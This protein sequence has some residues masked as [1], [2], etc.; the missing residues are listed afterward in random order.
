VLLHQG[1]P[2]SP[3]VLRR[4]LEMLEND[5]WTPTLPAAWLS[6]ASSAGIPPASY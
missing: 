5:G 6:A 3:E 2:H 4:V 1:L